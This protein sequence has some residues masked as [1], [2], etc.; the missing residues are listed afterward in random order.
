M[1]REAQEQTDLFNWAFYSKAK[2]PELDLMYHIPNGGSRNKIEA[3][4]LK[5]QG[6]KSGVPD[7]CLP[8]ARGEWHGLYIELKAGKNKP[9]GNQKEWILRLREQGY[10]A[11]VAVG[12]LQAKEL[13][14]A[15]LNYDKE[16]RE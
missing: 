6:V 12:W 7:I 8:V 5:R 10:A 1:Q 3:A 9:T 14:E 16:K 15:Y 11:E 13:I 4:H 2:Y